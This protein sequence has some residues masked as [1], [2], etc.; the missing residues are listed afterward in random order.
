MGMALAYAKI[1]SCV[2]KVTQSHCNNQVSCVSLANSPPF[3]KVSSV[4]SSLA[5]GK[6]KEFQS[7]FFRN[8]CWSHIYNGWM[9]FHV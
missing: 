2:F 5:I 7:I 8:F 6:L 9:A 4:T 3:T 1:E